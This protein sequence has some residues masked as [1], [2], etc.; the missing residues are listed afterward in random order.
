MSDSDPSEEPSF[1]IVS[2]F[3]RERNVLFAMANFS[4]LYVDYYLHL[5]DNRIEI[6]ADTAELLK[7]GLAA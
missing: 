3:I 7:R 6:D 1:S 2:S 4:P 5:K